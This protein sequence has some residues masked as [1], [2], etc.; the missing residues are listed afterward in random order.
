MTLLAYCYSWDLRGY[1]VSLFVAYL[2]LGPGEKQVLSVEGQNFELQERIL[3]GSHYFIKM[4]INVVQNALNQF[5]AAPFQIN[6]QDIQV[7]PKP[8]GHFL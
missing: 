7:S 2:R 5:S 4:N 6:L 1:L 8:V 3:F